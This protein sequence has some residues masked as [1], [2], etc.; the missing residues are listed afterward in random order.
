MKYI[1]KWFK[2]GWRG[3]SFNKWSQTLFN[4]SYLI[5]EQVWIQWFR[6]NIW[7][8][9]IF[10]AR[11]KNTF[12]E[13]T[14]NLYHKMYIIKFDL[15]ITCL[16]YIY[17]D[18]VKSFLTWPWQLDSWACIMPFLSSSF[19]LLFPCICLAQAQT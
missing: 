13:S 15:I 2:F 1:N 10:L 8:S 11:I 19:C 17:F 7:T 18:R 6:N 16:I 9:N 3:K 5:T 14:E 4:W 12:C